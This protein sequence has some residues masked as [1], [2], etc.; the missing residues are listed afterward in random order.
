[1]NEK[2]HAIADFYGYENQSLQ[3]IEEMAELTTA[4]NHVRRECRRTGCSLEHARSY[5]N[6]LE[7]IADVKLC[8]EQ[9]LYLL[10]VDVNDLIAAKIKRQLKRIEEKN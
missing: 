3:L 6:L 9:I 1:M 8:L 7:E 5:D 2:I 4:I 10:Q